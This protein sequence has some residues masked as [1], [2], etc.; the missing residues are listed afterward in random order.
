MLLC[1]IFYFQCL[2]FLTACVDYHF[3]IIG[4]DL[5]DA[6]VVIEYLMMT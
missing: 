3:V 4:L 2:V 1:L 5:M 6:E